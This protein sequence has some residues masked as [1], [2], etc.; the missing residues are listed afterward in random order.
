MHITDTTA[1]APAFARSGGRHIGVEL[2]R[3]RAVR[4]CN[5]CGSD[6]LVRS[7]RRHVEV[8]LS[9]LGLL[10]YRCVSCEKRCYR[11]EA[12]A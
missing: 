4:P 11:F 10:P 3:H 9:W 1:R 12:A 6:D 7:R 2:P 8:A 5:G